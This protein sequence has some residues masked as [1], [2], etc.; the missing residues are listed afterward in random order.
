MKSFPDIA[1][2]LFDKT[3]HFAQIRYES[4]KRLAGKE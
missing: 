3:Q 1:Q 4:Y 2:E